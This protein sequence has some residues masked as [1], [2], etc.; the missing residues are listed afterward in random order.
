MTKGDMGS[1]HE[2]GQWKSRVEGNSRAS[3]VHD[4][5]GSG[6]QQSEGPQS[7]RH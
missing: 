4:T 5:Q 6:A 2:D 3:N 7:D 1:Y